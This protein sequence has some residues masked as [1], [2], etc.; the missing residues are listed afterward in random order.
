MV[1]PPYPD[2]LIYPLQSFSFCLTKS[3]PTAHFRLSKQVFI[4]SLLPTVFSKSQS[5]SLFLHPCG[6]GA[7]KILDKGAGR[8]DGANLTMR[9][10]GDFWHVITW[11][12]DITL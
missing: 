6:L 11:Q 10:S 2:S 9:L 3:P 5:L 7:Q 8:G 12:C 4:S 1:L